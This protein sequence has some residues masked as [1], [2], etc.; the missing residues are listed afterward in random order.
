[1]GLYEEAVDL[2]LQVDVDLAKQSAEKP[3]D[4]EALRR[5]LWLRIAKHV[6]S[7]KNDIKKAMAVLHECPL[8]KIE[9]ILPFFPD[10]VTIDHFK[11]A[12]CSSL[13]DYNQ[14]IEA[15]KADMEDAS[16]S[17]KALRSDIQETRNKYGIVS[18][19]Q[20][21]ASCNYPL[22][23]RSFYLFPCEHM[24][25]S[26][27]LVTEIHPHLTPAKNIRIS[28]IQSQLTTLHGQRPQGSS[29]STEGATKREEIDRLRNELDDIVA[30]ECVYC[31]EIMIRSIDKPFIDHDEYEAVI[32]S[33]E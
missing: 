27:C 22:L 1:M 28:E 25:H 32:K 9:D 19:Q 26:D 5:K 21:C 13:A 7:E 16:E 31:G 4:D 2:A 12:I 29:T 23:T 6:V 15:L 18:G 24:F 11:D 17:A 33:W 30:A 14:H 10:F 8:L 3:E 20:K